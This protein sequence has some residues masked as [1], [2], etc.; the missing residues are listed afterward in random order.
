[1][2]EL[3]SGLK[4]KVRGQEGGAGSV[5]CLGSVV[6]PQSDGRRLK[7]RCYEEAKMKTRSGTS[8][9]AKS[10][11]RRGRARLQP[12][13]VSSVRKGSGDSYTESSTRGRM[14]IQITSGPV[15]SIRFT[16]TDVSLQLTPT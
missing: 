10:R 5:S 2:A 11:E 6:S 13:V 14:R 3:L 12:P 8:N 16:A 7:R 4:V 1:M 9:M 15:H